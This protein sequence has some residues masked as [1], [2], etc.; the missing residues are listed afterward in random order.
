MADVDVKDIKQDGTF[1]DENGVEQTA[2]SLDQIFGMLPKPK[3]NP[4]PA[5]NPGKL[6]PTPKR[7]IK[8]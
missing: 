5:P 4:N 3:Q 7:G 6:K 2:V 8:I 1:I